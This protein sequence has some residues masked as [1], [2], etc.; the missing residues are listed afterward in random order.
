[1]GPFRALKLALISVTTA[2]KN[3]HRFES[4][5]DEERALIYNYSPVN[6]GSSSIFEQVYYFW[7]LAAQTNQHASCWVMTIGPRED[8]VSDRF[9]SAILSHI[10][11]TPTALGYIENTTYCKIKP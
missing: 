5:E 9:L 8:S 7:F 2:R 4:K 6:P 10:F 1:M 3:L 11:E